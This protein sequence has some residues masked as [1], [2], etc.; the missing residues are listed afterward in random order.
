M[1]WIEWIA[2]LDL[3][4]STLS[5]N[6]KKNTIDLTAVRVDLCTKQ[7]RF[8]IDWNLNALIAFKSDI[9]GKTRADYKCPSSFFINPFHPVC[10][11]TSRCTAAYYLSILGQYLLET[12]KALLVIF[13]NEYGTGMCAIKCSSSGRV[14][15]NVDSIFAPGIGSDQKSNINLKIHKIFLSL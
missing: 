1:D 13:R 15:S 10:H 14:R 2:I 9:A 11:R 5:A 12:Y 4:A 8:E 3:I 6:N 7:R